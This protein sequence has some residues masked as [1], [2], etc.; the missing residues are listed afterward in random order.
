MC[1][2]GTCKWEYLSGKCGAPKGLPCPDDD[3][4]QDALDAWENQKDLYYDHLYEQRKDR[5]LQREW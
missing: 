4:Y 5:E 1:Y 2:S 3:G